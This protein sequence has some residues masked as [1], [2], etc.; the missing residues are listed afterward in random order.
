MHHDF[1]YIVKGEGEE[2][3]LEL[4]QT[5]SNHKK[6]IPMGIYGKEDG[7][8]Q[9]GGD[10][11]IMQNALL[12]SSDRTALLESP[13]YL[14]K[15]WAEERYMDNFYNSIY[16][17]E[18][19]KATNAYISRGCVCNCPYCSPGEFWKDPIPCHRIKLLEKFEIELQYLSSKGY[20]A[21]YFDEMAMP[22]YNTKWLVD[23]AI[24]L[25]NY[26]FFWG[27]SVIFDHVKG[28]DL[29]FLAKKGLRY[30]YFGY[31]TPIQKLQH[32]IR[33][34]TNEKEVLD[35]INKSNL[36]GIQ[37]DL[38]IIF[39][40]PGE[41][42]ESVLGTI[43]WLLKNLPRGN[44]FFSTAAIWP[45][46]EWARE[47]GLTPLSWEPNS[48]KDSYQNNAIW[49]SHSMTSIGQ[50]YV[51]SLGTYHPLFMTEKRAL[52]IKRMIID[53]GFRARFAKYSR[54]IKL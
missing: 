27:G 45:G 51:N 28:M 42:D 6:E 48:D 17:F 12:P 2:S 54:K 49:Y 16:S 43:D 26:N 9:Y 21:L 8:I 50:F 37:C 44:A 36:S 13:F 19:R 38:S 3:T 34:E 40:I 47:H 1:D 53:S 10:R 11:P 33:K 46:T 30:L 39:G 25:N 22:F 29:A 20:R 41:T 5:I 52:W 23:F 4:I 32:S 15:K 24:L 31:E 7:E 35:F 14:I 18:G